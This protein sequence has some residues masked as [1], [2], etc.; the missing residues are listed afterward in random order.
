MLDL[1]VPTKPRITAEVTR[2][3]YD[4]TL[5][6]RV[7]RSWQK[8]TL[9]ERRMVLLAGAEHLDEYARQMREEAETAQH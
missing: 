3:D 7:R 5:K 2:G 9:D 6:L 8:M 1:S 4:I